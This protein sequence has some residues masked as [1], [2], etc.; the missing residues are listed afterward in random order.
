[1]RYFPWNPE[2]KKKIILVGDA[3]PYSTPSGT[4]NIFKTKI[5]SL[6][7]KLNIYFDCILIMNESFSDA[8]ADRSYA[9]EKYKILERSSAIEEIE[10]S[11][12]E[13]K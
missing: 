5:E 3:E 11:V 10:K 6:S 2:A 4:E 9:S 1:M 8:Y 13:M 7:K 12:D